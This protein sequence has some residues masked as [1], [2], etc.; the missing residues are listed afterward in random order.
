VK[1]SGQLS[2][3]KAQIE[4]LLEYLEWTWRSAL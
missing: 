3:L 4:G 1:L 2:F